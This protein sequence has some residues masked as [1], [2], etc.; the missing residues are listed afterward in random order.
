[1]YAMGAVESTDIGVSTCSTLTNSIARGY[2]WC[3]EWRSQIYSKS[4]KWVE[5]VYGINQ[6]SKNERAF[7]AHKR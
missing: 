4:N 6:P 2:D 3:K 5:E 1:M 7:P